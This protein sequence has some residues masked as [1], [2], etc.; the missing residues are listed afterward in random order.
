LPDK[1]NFLPPTLRTKKRYL[2]YQVIS[3]KKIVFNDLTNAIWH[4]ALN[5]LGELGTSQA[6]LWIMK[7][8]YDN[9]RQIGLIRCS[10]TNVEKVRA[11]LALVQRIGDNLVIVKV[12]GISGTIKGAQRKFFGE[13]TLQ[14]FV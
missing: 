3:E 14:T 2:A 5:L 13:A 8:M 9:E 12:L 1:P 7:N 10:H 4:S 11:A 6:Q